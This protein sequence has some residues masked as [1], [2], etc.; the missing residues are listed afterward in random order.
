MV[1]WTQAL[2]G[3]TIGSAVF[4]QLTRVTNTHTDKQT[5]LSATSVA[6]GRMHCVQAVQLNVIEKSKVKLQRKIR[7][8]FKTLESQLVV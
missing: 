8:K 7:S 6:I 2:N 1:R 3:L 5:T 4:A